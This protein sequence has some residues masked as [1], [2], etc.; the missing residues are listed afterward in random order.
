M[1]SLIKIACCFLLLGTLACNKKKVISQAK[2]DDNVIK[3]YISEHNLNA[4]ETGSGLYYVISTEGTGA[5][6]N[7]NSF[8]TIN[9]KGTLTD[10]TVFDQNNSGSYSTSLTKVIKGWQEGVPL[11]K[12]GGKGMLLVPSALGYGKQANGSIPANSVLIFEIDLLDV[13]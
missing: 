7:I 3:K 9:Y 11:F 1:R 4:S 2:A 10:G 12:K 6:P 8:V 13:K 5:Q